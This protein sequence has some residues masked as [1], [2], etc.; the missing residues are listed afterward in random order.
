LTR[1]A[2]STDPQDVPTPSCHLR[3]RVAPATRYSPAQDLVPLPSPALHV[4]LPQKERRDGFH[5][6]CRSRANNR[7][8]SSRAARPVKGA[9]SPVDPPGRLGPIA[10]RSPRRTHPAYLADAREGHPLWWPAGDHYRGASNPQLLPA[11][12][13]PAG[14]LSPE[15]PVDQCDR[16]WQ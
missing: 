2:W 12:H 1:S 14:R 13:T 15:R 5:K 8:R 10:A 4:P 16:F 7:L 11:G 9:W 6:L 3:P